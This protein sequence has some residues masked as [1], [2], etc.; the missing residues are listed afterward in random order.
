LGC[1][2]EHIVAIGDNFNDLDMFAVA[3]YSIAVGNAPQAVKEQVD[4][5]CDACF[6]ARFREG[7]RHALERFSFPGIRRLP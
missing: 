7:V 4:Y 1:E 2:A 5:A 3:G 6:G